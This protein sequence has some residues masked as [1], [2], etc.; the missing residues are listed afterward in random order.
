MRH[1][2][3]RCDDAAA[4]H[5]QDTSAIATPVAPSVGDVTQAHEGNIP[6]TGG[7]DGQ[8]IEMTT[9]LRREFRQLR[10]TPYWHETV[11]LAKCGQ[12]RKPRIH[13][14]NL[15]RSIASE[16]VDIEVPS[17]ESG[18]RNIQPIV[19]VVVLARS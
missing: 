7:I 11:A 15:P 3:P 13:K 17:G 5:L 6:R 9:V 14:N 8:P 10:R 1:R 18:A 4:W 12:A 19:I 16:V 2:E